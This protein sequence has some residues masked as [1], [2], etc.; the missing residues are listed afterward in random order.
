MLFA[1]FE[2]STSFSFLIFTLFVMES[3]A[4]NLHPPFL[5]IGGGEPIVLQ[6]GKCLSI[7][8]CRF[9]GCRVYIT[10]VSDHLDA[11]G[12]PFNVF[13][14]PYL[15]QMTQKLLFRK[16]PGTNCRLHMRCSCRLH[17]RRLGQ[18][19]ASRV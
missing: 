14:S 1:F 9:S 16:F 15:Y 17:M 2:R 8:L 12:L 3:V 4:E 6:G 19:P 18:T 5:C 13:R 10:S 7:E 11:F